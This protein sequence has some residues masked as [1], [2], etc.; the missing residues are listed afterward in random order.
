MAMDARCEKATDL[1]GMNAV[2]QRSELAMRLLHLWHQPK[3]EYMGAV[4]ARNSWLATR[5]IQRLSK[6]A[7][8]LRC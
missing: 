2:H 4:C 7:N 5:W 8:L 1:S 3:S 6:I